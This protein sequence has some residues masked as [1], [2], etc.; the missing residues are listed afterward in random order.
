MFRQ[1]ELVAIFESHCNLRVAQI[2][3]DDAD[4]VFSPRHSETIEAVADGNVSTLQSS[5]SSV[6]KSKEC[7]N[8]SSVFVDRERLKF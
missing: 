4:N 7:E 3:Q 5:E 2:L 6:S 8:V 1:I